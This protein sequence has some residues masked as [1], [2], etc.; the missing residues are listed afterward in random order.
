MRFQVAAAARDNGL[1]L[2][3]NV[4]V[5]SDNGAS[6]GVGGVIISSVANGFAQTISG[7]VGGGI[8]GGK[9]LVL[10]V[11]ASQQLMVKAPIIDNGASNPLAVVISGGGITTF[12]GVNAYT[13]NTYVNGGTL[14]IASNI[15]LGQ[16]AL[17]ATLLLSGGVVNAA[18]SMTLDNSGSN[19]RPVVLGVSGGGLGAMNG[20]GLTV[21]GFISG[22]GGLT[23]TDSGGT[24][25]LSGPNTYQG[26]TTL[27][28]GILVITNEAANGTSGSLGVAPASAATS[29]TFSGSSSAATLQFAVSDLTLQAN[30]GVF[31]ANNFVASLDTLGNNETIAG[32]ISIAPGGALNKLSSGTLSLTGA[33]SGA[34]SIVVS[35]GSLV[36]SGANS[37]SGG[38]AI[39]VA[40]LRVSNGNNLGTGAV[41]ISGGMLSVAASTTFG[42]SMY[43]GAAS[44]G[45]NTIAVDANQTVTLSA[46]A[47]IHDASGT[48]SPKGLTFNG[49][50]TLMLQATSDYSHGTTIAAGIVQISSN[51]NLGTG[52]I[53]L[54]GGTLEVLTSAG[55]IN[56]TRPLFVAASS[57]ASTVL[58]DSG[59]NYN[60]N[61]VVSGGGAL[62]LGNGSCVGLG[63]N[64]AGF[65]GSLQ[66]LQGDVNVTSA[67]A[68]GASE[69]V[70][71]N[72][73]SLLIA[74]GLGTLTLGS[75]TGNGTLQ[76]G[77]N[78]TLFVAN[79]SGTLSATLGS[80]AILKVGDAGSHAVTGTLGVASGASNISLAKVGSGT[81]TW[82]G[83]VSN[84]AISVA[85]GT[86]ALRLGASGTSL[87]NDTVSLSGGTL[88]LTNDG[89]TTVQ[90]LGTLT[91]GAGL[92]GISVDNA[93]SNAAVTLSSVLSLN[94]N[95]LTSSFLVVT[96][97]GDNSL[98]A[99]NA[100]G[101]FNV[102]FSSVSNPLRSDNSNGS[103][104]WGS[105]NAPII[106]FAIYTG[107]SG[108]SLLTY[109]T[110]GA[111]GTGTGLRPL[112]SSEYVA[113][114]AA[115]D[116]VVLASNGNTV[117]ANTS[118]LSLLITATGTTTHTALTISDGSTLTIQN[119]LLAFAGTN[120]VIAPSGSTGALTFNTANALTGKV[121]TIYG[122]AGTSNTV[123]AVISGN[124]T[125][126]KAG[127]G[128]LNLTATNTYTGGTYLE[129]G[130]V[131]VTSRASISPGNTT[132]TF[133]GDAAIK[134]L[135]SL[136][137]AATKLEAG[138]TFVVNSGV[139]GTFDA[140]GFLVWASSN[141]SVSGTMAIAGGTFA[142]TQSS[143]VAK[144]ELNP[145][146]IGGATAFNPNSLLRIDA[147]VVQLATVS[148]ASVGQIQHGTIAINPQGALNVGIVSA[149]VL[150]L[151]QDAL[152]LN[153]G[154]MTFTLSSSAAMT[155][156]LSQPI[157]VNY[158]DTT[159]AVTNTNAAVTLSASQL[160]SIGLGA[161]LTLRL[162]GSTA[163]GG[164]A[165][166]N[167]FNLT[168]TSPPAPN[169]GGY[170]SG[171]PAN[172]VQGIVPG[173]FVSNGTTLSLATYI[174][175]AGSAGFRALTTSDSLQVT[176]TWPTV[177]T[178]S[179][180]S[181]W[182]NVTL[183]NTA[184]VSMTTNATI[185]SLLLNGAG[186]LDL[187]G[188]TLT[189]M[190]GVVANAGVGSNV[191]I[192]NGNLTFGSG[193]TLV[194]NGVTSNEGFIYTN[195]AATATTSINVTVTDA[196]NPVTLVIDSSNHTT[197]LDTNGVLAN[198][199]GVIVTGQN[200][201]FQLQNPNT[202][203]ALASGI[204]FAGSGST[205]ALRGPTP[206]NTS[207]WFV[208]YVSTAVVAGLTGAPSASGAIIT[209]TNA[210][211]VLNLGGI[212]EISTTFSGS[213]K[214]GTS[215]APLG[216]NAHFTNP[217]TTLTLTGDSM[218][219]NSF[220]G[221]LTLTSG[222]VA[223]ANPVALGGN[224]ANLSGATVTFAG[225]TLKIVGTTFD[226]ASHRFAIKDNGTIDVTDAAATLE[227][228]TQNLTANAGHLTVTGAGTLTL[229]GAAAAHTGGTSVVNGA[230][231][232]VTTTSGLTGDLTVNVNS[233]VVLDAN[234][235]SLG[236]VALATGGAININ[237]SSQVI[238]SLTGDN[239]AV[240]T[241]S[242]GA[243]TVSNS[244]VE[245]TTYDGRITGELNL[246]FHGVAGSAQVLTD[247]QSDFIGTTEIDSG[248]LIVNGAIV[249]NGG[250]T[251]LITVNGG[252]L[253]GSGV[254]ERNVTI[255]AGGTIAP[256]SDSAMPA[257]L[258][259]GDASTPTALTIQGTYDWD[260]RIADPT[261]AASS[262]SSDLIEL[263]GSNQTL[264]LGAGS[265]LSLAL[266]STPD[267]SDFWTINHIWNLVTGTALAP[268][269]NF[270][271]LTDGTHSSTTNHLG[272]YLGT[273]GYF[274]VDESN[275]N[276][277]RLEWIVA[278]AVPEPGA[279]LL[280]ILAAIGVGVRLRRRATHSHG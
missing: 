169:N 266:S 192:T 29:V 204:T 185:N 71:L 126:L 125:L 257:T 53:T 222:I 19:A 230:T 144:I 110:G 80:N 165:A 182:S 272:G 66:A 249:N 191:S 197:V 25:T 85:A 48:S 235:T 118:I 270:G 96:S 133:T 108:S 2:G 55:T 117:A 89:T 225:G 227:K 88:N 262:S 45:A 205:L 134:Y 62:N 158:G 178:G 174:A 42:Q 190:G 104:T 219:T 32:A 68:V 177:A 243:L 238:R 151:V 241:G 155:M 98:G 46:T 7:D 229:T 6:T 95:Y 28:S 280:G 27:S 115:G 162:G 82:T 34:G 173:V 105:P 41:T 74:D 3:G 43:L 130:T 60:L 267:A 242:S 47:A 265:V 213:F 11:N 240:I 172:G 61:G 274:T 237:N 23:K 244:Q 250:A 189:V 56:S 248:K 122:P 202:P 14:F 116:N 31:V 69:A 140:S 203:S 146:A 51:S 152:V 276:A 119:Q 9:E 112:T 149:T 176:T 154:T 253:A 236:S 10:E 109:D 278:T 187:Q 16:Q 220:S 268:L 258:T 153:G 210:G 73:N 18:T 159:W 90:T 251:T 86:L 4:L 214:D 15:S 128:Q 30:R 181:G 195:P 183:N 38:T 164:G 218:T 102:T 79:I 92:S 64:F 179:G 277:V 131:G 13:G 21:D 121:G 57:A 65:S 12:S 269:G 70:V 255:A 75:V 1:S 113:S 129:G 84:T 252:T 139:T 156:P 59:A 136:L 232:H 184:T 44:S 196:D 17:A 170:V 87:S 124:I 36:L 97:D 111:N 127:G 107:P 207:N 175:G 198:T 40:T 193:N 100:A 33:V 72:G 145:N 279:M 123:S 63:G 132:T 106:P 77:A 138:K 147:G 76:L 54:S 239:T 233:T 273:N 120:N 223:V 93:A 215:S 148:G 49:P 8:T 91:L 37:Y 142:L 200:T 271:T 194:V 24:M 261:Q 160:S 22:V 166:T 114:I 221:G 224:A 39:N 212:A 150:P 26:G 58:V 5:V 254:I 206:G 256:G 211:G 50:G 264:T 168:F 208:P 209:S 137:S 163:L 247:T 259:I 245:T 260:L 81:V 234:S 167:S 216:V 226:D 103:T 201:V 20:A 35:S 186:N 263:L 199:G 171:T 180:S 78:D 141:F 217:L 101:A 157:S 83:G 143:G 161:A 67:S 228:G 275:P 99:G 188:K 246:A 231:L 135:A 52:A 94:A